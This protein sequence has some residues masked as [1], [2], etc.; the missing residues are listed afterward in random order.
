MALHRARIGVLGS[1]LRASRGGGGVYHKLDHSVKDTRKFGYV[2]SVIDIF[3]LL[4]A[5]LTV[6]SS[7]K[8]FVYKCYE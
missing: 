4:I 5:G 2:Q 3:R 7:R 6:T 1:W 8:T